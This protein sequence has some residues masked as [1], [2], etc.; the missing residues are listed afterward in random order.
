MIVNNKPRRLLFSLATDGAGVTD[1]CRW[2]VQH[3][4]GFSTGDSAPPLDIML[5]FLYSCLGVILS[6]PRAAVLFFI[7]D[8]TFSLVFSESQP[9]LKQ[10]DIIARTPNATYQKPG[11]H[12]ETG[13]SE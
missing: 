5:P 12:R 7:D 6:T 2:A 11:F 10:G 9:D 8:I 3:L 1:S 13:D 4:G